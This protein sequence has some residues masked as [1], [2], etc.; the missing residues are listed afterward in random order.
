MKRGQ[1]LVSASLSMIALMACGAR[2]ELSI[3]DESPLSSGRAASS[4]G[5]FGSVPTN[6]GFGGALA[7][8]GSSAAGS[9][10]VGGT[11][12]GIGGMSGVGGAGASAG[13]GGA[14]GA[15]GS[16]ANGGAGG[17]LCTPGMPGCA[18]PVCGDGVVEALEACDD[19]NTVSGDGCSASC[20]WEP[21]A[22]SV[23][24]DFD[25]ALG[26]NGAVKCWG[27]NANGA[28]GLGDTVDRGGQPGQMGD[29]L[30]AVNLGTGRTARAIA[31]G[32][33]S[34]C[35]LLDNGTVKC[36]GL[37]VAG[38]L[39]VGDIVN[40]GDKPNE[41]GDN[42]PAVDLG[43]GRTAKAIATGNGSSCALLDNGTVKCWG[44]N[45]YGE[46]GLG[47]IAGRG[48]RP[49]QM[50]DNLP[51]VDLGTGRTAQSIA[52]GGEWT[53]ALLDNGTVKCWGY[54]GD[55]E[56]GLGDNTNRGEQPGQMGDNLPAASLG[57]GRTAR[58]I[59]AGGSNTC[60][61]LDD[62]T[63]KC[64]GFNRVGELGLGD[65]TE[66]GDQPGQMG[67][68]LPTVSL[69]TGRTA[70]AIAIGSSNTCALLDDGTVKCWGFNS[71]GELGLGDMN[72]RGDQPGQMG[73]NLPTVSLGTG[74]T[75]R[76]I[77]TGYTSVV[78]YSGSPANTCVLLDDGTVKCWGDNT[79]GQLGLGDAMN[80]GEL[81]NQMGDNLPAVDLT[82]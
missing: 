70:R 66:R 61:L 33:S 24:S 42:L 29:S 20:S 54:N 2:T 79:Y 9:G 35:A 76:A 72:E 18:L 53:C 46:L 64:W 44:E 55:G 36:W 80:R 65:V 41:M 74:R 15:A 78:A 27:N 60:A 73:D 39:G 8:A 3:F 81:P 77:A 6:A 47:D 56:L 52:A 50:G 22:V 7:T 19:G 14:S 1:T 37:N 43:T 69:G 31:S 26:F 49:G 28:L 21:R 17:A 63:V 34:T 58:A 51:T 13:F 57:T 82:F 75:A 32:S 23:G 62:G 11:N 67:D 71:E 16:D 40:R 68:N 5:G 45:A 48:G 38:E 10:A 25:C 12:G 30:P 4:A 59:A